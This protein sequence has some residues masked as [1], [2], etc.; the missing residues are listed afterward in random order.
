MLKDNPFHCFYLVLQKVKQWWNQCKSGKSFIKLFVCSC[1]HH[2]WKMNRMRE[3]SKDFIL[4]C[5][6]ILFYYFFCVLY[7]CMDEITSDG[8]SHSPSAGFPHPPI[9]TNRH[10]SV[11]IVKV[12]Q[13][14]AN[15]IGAVWWWI[16]EESWTLEKMGKR[17]YGTGLSVE[18]LFLIDN[19]MGYDVFLI[20][21]LVCGIFHNPSLNL[22]SSWD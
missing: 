18:L 9:D 2:K 21:S 20:L 22:S 16:S 14:I 10:F 15:V 1:A 4:F 19:Y 6:S 17:K 3:I 7:F 12:K 8:G 5:S 13:H 11:I